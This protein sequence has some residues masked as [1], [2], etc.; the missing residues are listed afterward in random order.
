MRKSIIALFFLTACTNA[1]GFKKLQRWMPNYW[2]TAKVI[3][4]KGTCNQRLEDYRTNKPISECNNRFTCA[5]A[6][7]CILEETSETM[8]AK[9]ASAALILGLTPTILAFTG[10]SVAEISVL[11]AKSPLLAVLL[12]IASPAVNQLQ[13]FSQSVTSKDVL[14]SKTTSAVARTWYAWWRTQSSNTKTLYRIFQYIIVVLLIANSIYT[15]IYLDLRTVLSFNC[16]LAFMPLLWS[17]LSVVVHSFG[18]LSMY[19]RQPKAQ[20]TTSTDWNPVYRRNWRE[21]VVREDG[22]IGETLIWVA[23]M[24]GIMH[25]IFA[26]MVFSSLLL[27]TTRDAMPILVRYAASAFASQMI[28]V[29]ELAIM[30][31][32]EKLVVYREVSQSDKTERSNTL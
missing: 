3:V 14:D 31:L 4:D 16:G 12:G 23:S 21:M 8:K 11:S 17:L 2:D 28:L 15:G 9:L 32:D 27:L 26:T 18:I 22:M 29:S 20:V 13:L 6:V 24:A 25:M 5:C 19:I 30:R 10:P 7:D 1:H